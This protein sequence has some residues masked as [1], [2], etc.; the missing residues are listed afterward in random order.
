MSSVDRRLERMNKR[1]MQALG[2]AI[3][4]GTGNPM[5]KTVSVTRVETSRDYKNAKVHF[6]CFDETQSQVLQKALATSEGFFRARIEEAI[7]LPMV[8]HLTF[9]YDRTLVDAHRV[10]ELMDQIKKEKEAP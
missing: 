3:L 7:E 4:M 1:I 10:K 5:F 8:P 6:S 2:N 9:V